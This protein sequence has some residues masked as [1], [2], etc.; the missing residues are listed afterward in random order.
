MK[1]SFYLLFIFFTL[2]FL[3]YP[4]DS[5]YFNLFAYNR[6]IFNREEQQ[7]NININ[8]IPLVK[9]TVP[10][11]LTAEG[12][13]VLELSTFTPLLQHNIHKKFYPAS[14][15]KVIT[16]LVSHDIYNLDDIVTVK[17]IKDEGQ[18]MGLYVGERISVGNL[19]YGLLVH[20]G[21][22]AAYALAEHKGFDTFVRLM[23]EKSRSLGMKD[24]YFKNPAGLDDPSQYT[25][26]FD[27]A[28]ASRELL[29]NREL[30]KIVATKEIV[31]SDDDFKVFHQLSNVNRLLGE[32]QGIG[33]L[34]T[35]Y[36]E[37]AGENLV[38]LYKQNGHEYL[39]VV[40]KSADRFQDTK[41][42]V[43]WLQQNID[44]LKLDN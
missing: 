21:N 8:P 5:Y 9:N 22:D 31:I 38:S 3:F 26:P 42:I 37:N 30:R 2:L 44:Y 20:S 1:I 16:S 41:S 14:T 27:L 18:T 29:K 25:T 10:P 6:P 4:G 12:Y 15:T 11:F 39:I 24:S 40:L 7:H 17:K 23:N 33:G 36:T 35:G 13:Y 32:V 28:L 19:L 43:I 34:K